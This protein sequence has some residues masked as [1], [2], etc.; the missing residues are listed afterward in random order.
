ME[1]DLSPPFQAPLTS[2]QASQEQGGAVQAVAIQPM[3]LFVFLNP[4]HDIITLIAP[5]GTN[6]NLRAEALTLSVVPVPPDSLSLQFQGR[7]IGQ[8]LETQAELGVRPGD[9]L[10]HGLLGKCGSSSLI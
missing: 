7:P 2:N 5:D 4:G 9:T 1:A 3:N 10:R 6:H 8:A